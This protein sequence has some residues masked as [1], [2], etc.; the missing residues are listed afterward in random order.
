MEP[1]LNT[2]A[3]NLLS[4]AVETRLKSYSL[5]LVQTLTLV[6]TSPAKH[7]ILMRAYSRSRTDSKKQDHFETSSV[8]STQVSTAPCEEVFGLHPMK[9]EEDSPG[10]RRSPVKVPKLRL[11]TASADRNV[12]YTKQRSTF[13]AGLDIVSKLKVT[14]KKPKE[15]PDKM[16]RSF[17]H[18]SATLCHNPSD[19]ETAIE[20]SPQK[21][22]SNYSQIQRTI[23]RRT[24]TPSRTRT[25]SKPITRPGSAH[26]M[27]RQDY[28]IKTEIIRRE[29]KLNLQQ[30]DCDNRVRQLPHETWQ[31]EN[32]PRSK[33]AY[34]KLPCEAEL[35]NCLNTL[36][37]KKIQE[38]KETLHCTPEAADVCLG[39]MMLF[40]DVDS[41]IEA[42][43]CH[44][45][46]KSKRNEQVANYFAVPGHVIAVCRKFIPHVKKGMVSFSKP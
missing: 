6:A 28:P 5:Q 3:V 10:V 15:S 30:C 40:T 23:G 14:P 42:S 27:R 8:A 41:S 24:K 17:N 4:R 46:L 35:F 45:T 1:K 13:S 38:V 11:V 21:S 36:T 33:V 39:L 31:S 7:R 25:S 20:D 22:T 32:G 12:S 43:C 26:N 18:S 44:R 37:V 9:I 2:K 34:Q 19:Y 29:I 16:S